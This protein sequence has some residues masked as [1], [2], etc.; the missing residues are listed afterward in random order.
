MQKTKVIRGNPIYVYRGT[1]YIEKPSRTVIRSMM[2]DD[3]RNVTYVHCRKPGKKIE[4]ICTLLLI[5]C[6]V[7]NVLYLHR[8]EVT[9]RYNSIVTYYNDELYL[10]LVNDN[11]SPVEVNF[12]LLDDGSVVASGILSPGDTLI[13]VP[14]QSIKDTYTLRF[15]YKIFMSNHIDDVSIHVIDRRIK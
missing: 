4:F 13:S 10:N 15:T 8:T 2:Y 9:V 7:F 1:N 6:V 12:M 14:V 11:T 5:A 3:S